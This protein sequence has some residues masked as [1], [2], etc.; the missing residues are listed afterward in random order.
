M[1]S[2]LLI[3]LFTYRVNA[4]SNNLENLLVSYDNETKCLIRL[5]LK[6]LLKTTWLFTLILLF[7]I[8]FI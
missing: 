4:I 7:L 5:Q 6:I 2:S 3:K 1:Y 8:Y